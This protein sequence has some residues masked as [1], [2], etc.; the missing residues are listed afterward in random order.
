MVFW[1]TFICCTSRVPESPFGGGGFRTTEAVEKNLPTLQYPR[2]VFWRQKAVFRP[3]REGK[4]ASAVWGSGEAGPFSQVYVREKKA[5]HPK[6]PFPR[7]APRPAGIPS[8]RSFPRGSCS[9]PPRPAA[10]LRKEG[11]SGASH[12]KAAL[13]EKTSGQ[14]LLLSLRLPLYNK[15]RK[16][17]LA[18]T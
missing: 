7:I 18:A 11:A 10:S 16:K 2:G 13:T 8:A 4:G 9:A 6:P 15:V 3:S 17:R 1:L 14:G 12:K 5:K